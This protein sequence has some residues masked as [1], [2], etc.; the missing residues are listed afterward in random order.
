MFRLKTDLSSKVGEE[1]S[2][3]T[4]KTKVS[5]NVFVV[6]EQSDATDAASSYH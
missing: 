6:L 3:Y 1:M 5:L 4:I 2:N